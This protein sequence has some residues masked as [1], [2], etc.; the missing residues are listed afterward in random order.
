M[1]KLSYLFVS[2]KQDSISQWQSFIVTIILI[3]K[4]LDIHQFPARIESSQH[5]A[6]CLV[7]SISFLYKK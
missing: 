3:K 4:K 6:E 2:S 1:N 7:T 5:T